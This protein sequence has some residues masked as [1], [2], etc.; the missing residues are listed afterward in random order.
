MRVLQITAFSGWGCTGRIAVGIHNALVAEGYESK[1]AWGRKNTA[2]ENIPTIKIGSKLDQQMHG[3]Y[4]RIT[5]KCGF[6]SKYITKEFLKQIDDYKPDLIQLHILHGYYINLELLF[7]YIKE[8]NIPTVWTF[9]DCWAFTGHCPYFDLVGCEK[10][11]T[12]CHEC[13]QKAHHP[14]SWLMDN[15]KWNWEKKRELYGSYERLTIVTPSRWLSDLVSQSFLSSCTVKVIHNGINLEN[16]KPV[17][18]SFIEHKNLE[19]KTV[20]LGVSSTWAASKGLDDFCRLAKTLPTQYQIVLVG[21]DEGQINNLPEEILGIKRTDSVQELAE[22]YSAASLFI[23][24]TYED[25]F[26]TTNIEALAS[27]TPVVTYRTG[28]SVEAAGDEYGKIIPQGDVDAL[29]LYILSEEWRNI[30]KSSCVERAKM[31]DERKRF[32]E[33]V[34][35]YREILQEK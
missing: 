5:D 11:K 31:F 21:L 10:W 26:P 35:L 7:S 1:I 3:L 18:G 32:I 27:G 20:I 16:F 13:P 28:G 6:G 23:N 14:T 15:S 30:K 33:Y 19:N 22:L 8:R 9:H 4:T 34:D 24:P 17:K 2:P 29:R 12:G 25:N